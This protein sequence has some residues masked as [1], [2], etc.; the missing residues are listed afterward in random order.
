[1]KQQGAQLLGPAFLLG[2]AL[3]I[4]FCSYRSSVDERATR[5]MAPH[6]LLMT[7]V[8]CRMDL[9]ASDVLGA[10]VQ[11]SR[12]SAGWCTLG[13]ETADSLGVVLDHRV[14]QG[15]LARVAVGGAVSAAQYGA[16]WNIFLNADT[17]RR[18][19]PGHGS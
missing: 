13:E 7:E 10:T 1:M 11:A 14:R 16:L 6:V 2:C 8:T 12:T 17:I 9:S 5:S 3:G 4:L 18:I 15:T 19:D